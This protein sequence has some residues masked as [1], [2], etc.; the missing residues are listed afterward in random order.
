MLQCRLDDQFSTV[1]S[2]VLDHA[3]FPRRAA[4]QGAAA[5]LAQFFQRHSL[6]GGRHSRLPR[7]DESLAQLNDAFRLVFVAF[8]NGLA[9]KGI[10]YKVIGVFDSINLKNCNGR[11]F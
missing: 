9:S 11:T 2:V 8:E 1:C 5:G 6:A 3:G 4:L 7:T 10:S